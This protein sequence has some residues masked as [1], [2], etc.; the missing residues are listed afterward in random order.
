MIV[1]IFWIGSEDSQCFENKFT[2]DLSKLNIIDKHEKSI[3][4][5]V[6]FAEVLGKLGEGVVENEGTS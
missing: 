1:W 2:K 5:W 4:L 6:V 3:T